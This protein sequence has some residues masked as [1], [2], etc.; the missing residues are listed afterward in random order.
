MES[1]SYPTSGALNRAHYAL[2][3]KIENT[4]SSSE[5]ES[6]ILG[7]IN[8]IRNRIL[9]GSGSGFGRLEDLA[10]VGVFSFQQQRHGTL[11]VSSTRVFHSIITCLFIIL[12]HISWCNQAKAREDL[13]LLLYCKTAGSSK[14]I[15]AKN[16]NLRFHMLLPWQRAV[17]L[18]LSAVQVSSS[19]S[20]L[21]ES[22]QA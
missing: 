12:P 17:K 3:A 5:V 18:L 8:E 19:S 13:L 22:S 14:R 16:S 9:R 6:V 1:V 7:V 11:L 21:H 20:S 2:V 10:A 15:N 4:S